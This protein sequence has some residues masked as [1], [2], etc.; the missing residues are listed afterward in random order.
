MQTRCGN[1]NAHYLMFL[2]HHSNC[3]KFPRTVLFSIFLLNSPLSHLKEEKKMLR[4]NQTYISL[5]KNDK[6]L[7][8]SGV[9]KT[10]GGMSTQALAKAAFLRRFSRFLASVSE[11]ILAFLRHF[12][13][14]FLVISW[15]TLFFTTKGS[16]SQVQLKIS[17]LKWPIYAINS[18]DN[19]KLLHIN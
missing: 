19:T 4:A 9:K 5:E 14:L 3:K 8:S 13:G 18:V 2:C 6:Q 1:Y 10:V 15:S 12:S 11:S 17:Y 7:P 16:A